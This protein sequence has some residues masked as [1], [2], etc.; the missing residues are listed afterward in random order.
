MTVYYNDCSVAAKKIVDYLGKRIT[1]GVPLGI[2]KPIGLLNALYQLAYEDKSIQLTILTALTLARPKLHNELEKRFLQPLLER[3]LKDYED[4]QYEIARRAQ[5]LPPN[6]KVI[7]FFL[8]PAE[9]LHNANVQENYIS[10]N[11]TLVARDLE[12]FSMNILAQQV[13]RSTSDPDSISLSSNTDLFFEVKQHLDVRRSQGE[14]IVIAAEINQNLPFMYEN[15]K[16]TTETFTDIIDTKKYPI[17]F[18]IPYPELSAKDH[19][20]GLYTS[21]LIKDDGCLQI[22]IGK[23]GDAITNSLI[24]RHKNNSVYQEIL[25]KLNVTEKFGETIASWGDTLPFKKGLYAST[26]MLCE[27]YIY[28]YKEEVLKKHVYDD[29]ILQK[30]LNL[31]TISEIITPEIID[32]LLENKAINAKLTLVDFNFLQ[33]FGI[34]KSVIKYQDEKLILP[35]G[36]TVTADLTATHTKKIIIETCL[37]KQLQTGKL[38]HAGFF[39]GSGQFYQQLRD[40]SS[41]E[42]S[43]FEMTTVAR[44]NALNWAPELL[45]LQR[46]QARFVNTTMMITLG[47]AAVSDGLLNLQELS[48]VGGQFNF[49]NM[50]QEIPSARSILN[51]HSTRHTKQGVTSNIIWEYPNVTVPRHLRDIVITDYG[52]ADCRAKTD[53]EIIHALLNITDSR[54]QNQLL[55]KAKKFGKISQHYQ[56]PKQFQQNLPEKFAAIIKDLQSKGYCKPYPFGTEL[57]AVEILLKNTL[58]YLKNST[59]PKLLFLIFLALISFKSDKKYHPYLSRMQLEKPKTIIEF[60]YKKLLKLVIDKFV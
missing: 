21:T 55:N 56:I 48:G 9:Y 37:G 43:Q 8:A 4:P 29:V 24:L 15:P 60:T 50:A 40:L 10:S 59:K 7:E 26:E 18:P 32:I 36:E 3:S 2:G 41:D 20:I 17:L 31:Q 44:T 54:F 51:C 14:K 49:V 39:L 30:L 12:H 22:G 34:F 47:G 16:A 33:K 6:I 58:F 11:Y 1:I 25:K 45:K 27:G 57:T 42:L 38:L 19:L 35:S 52:I 13:A 53:S 28:L 5:Q 23:L 46:Q